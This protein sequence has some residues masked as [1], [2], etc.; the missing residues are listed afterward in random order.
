MY[1]LQRVSSALWG[2]NTIV[3]SDPSR[4]D[5]ISCSQVAFQKAPNVNYAKEGG[6]MEWI[7]DV[8]RID[9]IFGDGSSGG[10]LTA[11]AA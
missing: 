10:A 5:Q 9:M 8:G 3:V 11:L 7:F 2:Q 6:T 1:D 4:G